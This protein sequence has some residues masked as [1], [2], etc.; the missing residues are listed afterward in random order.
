MPK[1]IISVKNLNVSYISNNKRNNAL[2]NINFKLFENEILGIIGES[3][4]GKTTLARYLLGTLDTVGSEINV[5]EYTLNNTRID[6]LPTEINKLRG[7]FISMIM[8]NPVSSLNLTMKIHNQFRLVLKDVLNIKKNELQD[9]LIEEVIRDVSLENHKD[10]L[11]KYPLEL[12]DGMNQ[13]INVA[14]SLINNPHVLVMDEPTSSIDKENKIR[15]LEVIDKIVNKKNISV[16]FIT[17]DILLAKKICNRVLIMKDNKIVDEIFKDSELL[18]NEYTRLLYKSSLLDVKKNIEAVFGQKIIELNTVSKN[19]GKNQVVKDFSMYVKKGETLGLVGK[20][21]VGK[22][23]ICKI[24]MGI[25]RPSSGL[26][27]NKENLKIEMVFQNANLSLNHNQ[28]I[29]KILNEENYIN[30]KDE[31]SKE[32]ISSFLVDFNLPIDILDKFI[33]ELSDG[34]KQIISIIRSLLSSPDVIILDE[35]TSSLDII[36]QNKILDLL[37]QIKLKY[38]LTY[39]LISHDNK[40]IQYMCNRYIEIGDLY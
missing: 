34:Q 19:F 8:Q 5:E 29:F 18:N 26:I 32:Y 2:I 39:L 27:N 28:K 33:T 35:P 24:I 10:I 6:L 36:T 14:L 4:S 38:N 13:R 7:S 1:E 21:G 22:T 12:S 31:F 16:V 3:G 37:L 11:N 15:I 9:S 40:V 17:H 23:T 25:Y 20:S 30:K